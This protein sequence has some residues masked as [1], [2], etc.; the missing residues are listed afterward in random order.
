MV[1]NGTDVKLIYVTPPVMSTVDRI[2]DTVPEVIDKVTDFI[3]KD[4]EK[5]G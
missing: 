3:S 1:V 5:E 2:I 4:K